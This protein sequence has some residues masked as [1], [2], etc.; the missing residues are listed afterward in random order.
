LEE[1]I[2]IVVDVETTGLD[3]D[4]CGIISIGAVDYARPEI[5]FYGECDPFEFAVIEESALVVNGTLRYTFGNRGPETVLLS[6]FYKWSKDKECKVLIGFNVG[7]FDSQFLKSGFSRVGLPWIYGH[8]VID[9]HSLYVAIRDPS[10]KERGFCQDDIA[11][12]VGL[13]KEPH[14][15]NA[16]T[17]AKWAAEVFHRLRYGDSLISDFNHYSFPDWMSRQ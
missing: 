6:D 9:L 11:K 17:G 13:P 8:R 4:A 10:L 1:G 12:D 14:P 16:L 2:M 7:Q 5:V 15:H 3:H